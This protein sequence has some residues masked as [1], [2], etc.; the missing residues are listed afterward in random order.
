[1]W[2]LWWQG[3]E[4]IYLVKRSSLFPNFN[5]M[6]H[7]GTINGREIYYSN[8]RKDVQ[9]AAQLP[10]KHWVLFLFTSEPD[11]DLVNNIAVA[12]MDNRLGYLCAAGHWASYAEDVFDEEYLMRKVMNVRKWGDPVYDDDSV[13]MTTFHR[14]TDEAFW[15]AAVCACN[16]PFVLDAVVCLD[17]SEAGIRTYLQALVHKINAQ[18]LPGYEDALLP[19]YDA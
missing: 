4:L 18:W 15:Y 17:L 7:L 14:N 10:A 6:D 12:C 3:M 9:W 1:M 19:E 8:V 13:L 2:R 11:R 5:I 16:D